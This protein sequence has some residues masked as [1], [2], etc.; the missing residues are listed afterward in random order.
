MKVSSNSLSAGQLPSTCLTDC[1]L[2]LGISRV[3]KLDWVGTKR[4]SQEIKRAH[5]LAD[6]NLT[7]SVHPNLTKQLTVENCVEF[8]DLL[9]EDLLCSLQKV[10]PLE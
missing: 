2:G 9:L 1:F 4:G 8:L 7:A 3:L 6:F 5:S 10:F